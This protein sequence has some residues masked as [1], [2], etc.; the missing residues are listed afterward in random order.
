MPRIRMRQ[1]E[2]TAG[3]DSI[4]FHVQ[5][6]Q[7]HLQ[8]LFFMEHTEVCVDVVAQF[9]PTGAHR[10]MLGL[11]CSVWERAECHRQS[12]DPMNVVSSPPALGKD[13]CRPLPLLRPNVST[14]ADVR[15]RRQLHGDGDEHGAGDSQQQLV[16]QLHVRPVR[17]L[18][19]RILLLLLRS[20][21][22][23]PSPPPLHP[24]P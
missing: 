5:P 11:L 6:G 20:D 23:D 19:L 16:C 18:A 17:G 1:S 8:Q 7:W 22:V 21:K 2:L 3:F 14:S 24:L 12:I 13:L 9:S 4:R 15:L 10:W